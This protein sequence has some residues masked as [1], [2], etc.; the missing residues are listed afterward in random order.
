MQHEESSFKGLKD[1][2]IYYQKWLPS[3]KIKAVLLIS[4]GFAEHSSRYA[5][6]VNHFVPKGYA[7]YA[8]DHRGH[9]RSDGERVRTESFY[10]Y[11]DDLKTFFNIVRQEMPD[12]KIFLIGHSMGSMIALLYTARYQKELA[13]LVTSGGGMARPGD[14]PMARRP[15]GESLPSAMLSRD[16]SVIEAYENDPLVYRGP[17]PTDLA[18]FSAAGE[19]P[20]TVP[21]ITIPVLIMA[22]NGGPDG[23]RSQVL[24]EYIG[25]SDKT[26]KLYEDLLHE[27]FNEPEYPLVMADLERWL[28][29]HL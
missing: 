19:I 6:V 14:P 3:A 23:A 9:G 21:R 26:L 15:A 25:S 18:L 29:A 16:P 13:G 11:V 24:Y 28:V 1:F 2:N 10:D 12:N 20:E 5:N 27:I 8:L 4:H 22:G 7:I 17:I